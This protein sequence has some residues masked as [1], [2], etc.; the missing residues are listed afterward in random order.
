LMGLD[1]DRSLI[2]TKALSPGEFFCVFAI[3][4]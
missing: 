4:L 1:A 2:A 3:W